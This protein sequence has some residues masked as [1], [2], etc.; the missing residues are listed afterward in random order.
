MDY[1]TLQDIIKQIENKQ[2]DCDGFSKKY[3]IR[4]MEDLVQYYEGANWALKFVL[5]II[6]EANKKS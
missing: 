3:R 6:E 5:S 4:N 2:K 1:E